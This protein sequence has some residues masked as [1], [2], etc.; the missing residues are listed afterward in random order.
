MSVVVVVTIDDPDLTDDDAYAAVNAAL[1][2]AG[3]RA[4]S[5]Y[6]AVDGAVPTRREPSE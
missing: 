3:F 5:S 4:W 1:D 2:F 6:L